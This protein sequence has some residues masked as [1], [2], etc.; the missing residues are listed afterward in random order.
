MFAKVVSVGG[1]TEGSLKGMGRYP[2]FNDA[3]NGVVVELYKVYENKLVQI[4]PEFSKCEHDNNLA[5][6][7]CPGTYSYQ[8]IIIN[9]E[10]NIVRLVDK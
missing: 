5:I 3:K 1:Q 6:L 4:T 9:D 10:V 7:S 8:Q 2:Y